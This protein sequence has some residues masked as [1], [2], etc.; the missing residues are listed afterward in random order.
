MSARSYPNL[1]IDLLEITR[2]ISEVAV[3][4]GSSTAP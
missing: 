4:I 2:A 3:M 1:D